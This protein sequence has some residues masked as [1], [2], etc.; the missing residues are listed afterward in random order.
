[1]KMNSTV[2]TIYADNSVLNW[3]SCTGFD[4][5]LLIDYRGI[6]SIDISDYIDGLDYDDS[7]FLI[8]WCTLGKGCKN[9][10]KA[11]TEHYTDVRIEIE[12]IDVTQKVLVKTQVKQGIVHKNICYWSDKKEL[13][14]FVDAHDI[15]EVIQDGDVNT[16]WKQY[17][18]HDHQEEIQ[19]SSLLVSPC[20]TPR[21]CSPKTYT[22]RTPQKLTKNNFYMCYAPKKTQKAKVIDHTA[23]IGTARILF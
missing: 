13:Q 6:F 3:L 9:A 18:S 7:P 17:Q 21:C 5:S 12:S 20:A 10:F 8:M 23:L 2:V 16:W 14:H 11:L 22:P 1:M 4:L 15:K 19:S